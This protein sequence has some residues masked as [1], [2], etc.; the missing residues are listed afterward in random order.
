MSFLEPQGCSGS[1]AIT[2]LS[3]S[4][5]NWGE[6]EFTKETKGTFRKLESEA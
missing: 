5:L 4:G 6:G 3:K 1:F 2:D